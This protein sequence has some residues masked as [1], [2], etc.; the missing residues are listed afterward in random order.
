MGQPFTPCSPG[1][2]GCEPHS[3][4]IIISSSSSRSTASFQIAALTC[5]ALG[6]LEQWV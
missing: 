4:I 2:C 3:H 6:I 1:K 5:C